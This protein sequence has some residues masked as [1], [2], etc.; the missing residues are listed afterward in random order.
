M[1]YVKYKI[2][3]ELFPYHIINIFNIHAYI[4]IYISVNI[5]HV[6]DMI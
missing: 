4:F 6:N 3:M 2:T 1:R 5:E